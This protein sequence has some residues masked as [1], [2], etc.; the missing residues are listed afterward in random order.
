MENILK[1]LTGE[2]SKG[3]TKKEPETEQKNYV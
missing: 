3:Y 2:A 1:I